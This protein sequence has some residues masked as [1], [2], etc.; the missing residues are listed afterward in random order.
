MQ[1]REPL[2]ETLANSSLEGEKEKHTDLLTK[3]TTENLMPPPDCP[4]SDSDTMDGLDG[5]GKTSLMDTKTSNRPMFFFKKKSIAES[6]PNEQLEEMDEVS[7]LIL[8]ASPEELMPLMVPYASIKDK[9]AFFKDHKRFFACGT[10]RSMLRG[11]GATLGTYRLKCNTCKSGV[12]LAIA[13]EC[14]VDLIKMCHPETLEEQEVRTTCEDAKE[15]TRPPWKRAHLKRSLSSS[16]DEDRDMVAEAPGEDQEEESGL[17]SELKSMMVMLTQEVKA[18]REENATIRRENDELRR[19]VL[20][21]ARPAQSPIQDGPRPSRESYSSILTSNVPTS[22]TV[23]TDPKVGR[24]SPQRGKEPSEVNARPKDHRA[25]E[26][27]AKQPKG[28]DLPRIYD[29]DLSAEEY[30]KLFSGQ[31]IRP[32]KRITALYVNKGK[33]KTRRIS[34]LR[35]ILKVYAGMEMRNVLHIDYVGQ[36]IVE[37]HLYED[38]LT[39][40]KAI[41]AAKFPQWVILEGLDPLSDSLLKRSVMEDKMAEAANKYKSRLTKR[42]QSTP[43]AAHRRFLQREMARADDL[44]AKK[45]SS[46]MQVTSSNVTCESTI[47]QQC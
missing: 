34:E 11:D 1:G 41:A 43:S 25:G 45:Q 42:I 36:S 40:F 31:P 21:I 29:K 12:S 26:H 30:Q 14:L 19:L 22:T 47:T 18:L 24:Q 38:Y 5:D 4:E 16:E 13:L 9:A 37:F 2:L 28:K 35:H 7:N 27:Q 33:G 6:P 44:L 15:I 39:D 10:C 32:P 23:T 3:T 17:V 46:D 8:Q 20:S